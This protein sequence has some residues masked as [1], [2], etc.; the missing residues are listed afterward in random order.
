MNDANLRGNL[1]EIAALSN[2]DPMPC[3]SRSDVPQRS[4][5]NGCAP[6]V[7]MLAAPA[8]IPSPLT[9]RPATGAEFGHSKK[10]LTDV[11]LHQLKTLKQAA[12]LR[13]EYLEA[14]RLKHR[15]ALVE[16]VQQLTCQ[17]QVAVR[18][19]NYIEADRLKRQIEELEKQDVPNERPG[20]PAKRSRAQLQWSSAATLPPSTTQVLHTLLTTLRID[21]P[22]RDSSSL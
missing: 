19:E 9:A 20:S 22:L 2:G 18:G 10:S 8:R 17:K 12:V 7:P 11:D 21:R 15:I 5:P 3:G 14:E 4:Q 16:K 6:G 1:P 13:E